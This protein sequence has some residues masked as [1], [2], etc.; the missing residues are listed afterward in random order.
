VDA[1]EKLSCGQ[2]FQG[3]SL[4]GGNG[5]HC[6]SYAQEGGVEGCRKGAPSA[7]AAGLRVESF[8]FAGRG[9]AGRMGASGASRRPSALVSASIGSSTRTPGRAVQGQVVHSMLANDQAVR[10]ALAMFFPDT[11]RKRRPQPPVGTFPRSRVGRLGR[12]IA[13]RLTQKKTRHRGGSFS[14]GAGS[15]SR[16][17][18][19]R[20]PPAG[21][22]R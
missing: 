17:G 10:D 13:F 12:G 2:T 14:P 6:A 22:C 18:A 9:P 5:R 20:V 8:P 3:R 11:A 16:S 1:V 7:A 21:A 4:A 15:L 19:P